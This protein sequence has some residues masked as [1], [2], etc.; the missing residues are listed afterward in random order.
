MV[1]RRALLILGGFA[2]VG[3]AL[4][5]FMTGAGVVPPPEEPPEVPPEEIIDAEILSISVS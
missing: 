2:L 3:T 5:L 1:E 4:Y